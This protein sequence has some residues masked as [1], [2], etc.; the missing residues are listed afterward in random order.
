MQTVETSKTR[1]YERFA[2]FLA[3]GKTQT[4]EVKTWGVTAGGALV[5]AAVVASAAQSILALFA[6]LTAPPVALTVGVLGGGFIGWNYMHRCQVSGSVVAP[7]TVAPCTA[8]MDDLELINGV[9]ATYA[10]RLHA[11]GI[12]TFAQL[13]E[14]TPERVHL[15]IGPT[16][17]STLI[18]STSW[19]AE[20]RH[21]ANGRRV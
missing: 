14:L 12:D 5:G 18:H 11:A 2:D 21:F 4:D 17:D 10:A 15:I 16:Y 3:K 9:T 7:T 19:I 13:A 8:A 6:W 20:A 1:A